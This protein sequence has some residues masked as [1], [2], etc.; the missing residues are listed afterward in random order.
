MTTTKFWIIS[1]VSW[2]FFLVTG[3]IGFFKFAIKNDN[4]TK[5][6]WSFYSLTKKSDTS[7]LLF[8]MD[9]AT[10]IVVFAILMSIGTIA[11]VAYL[12][13]TTIKKE[14]HIFDGIVGKISRYHFI[15]LICASCLF[16]IGIAINDSKKASAKEYIVKFAFNLVF[17][18]LGLFSLVFVKSNTTIE[19]PIYIVY[20][21]KDG[22]YS[23][24]IALFTYCFFYSIIYIGYFDI[25]NDISEAMKN[26][27]WNKYVE[28]SKRMA[29]FNKNCHI[30]FS[31]LTGFINI[32]LG[33][34]LKDI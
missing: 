23:F 14:E 31:I 10:Y 28:L 25:I 5:F 2:L 8:N 13:K 20:T 15:P 7:G 3:W 9:Y 22:L 24:L 18:F 21:I 34:I 33:F 17:A 4:Y 1:L 26:L 6:I 27:D 16:I 12:F 29:T 11:F 32:C 19:Q 30:A